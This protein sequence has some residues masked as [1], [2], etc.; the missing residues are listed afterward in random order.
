VPTI[1]EA[2]GV[3]YDPGQFYG[4]SAL[5]MLSG[6]S[7]TTYSDDEGFAFEVSGN[8]AL[9]RG[10]WKITRNTPPQ[11]DSEWRLY[12][13]SIDPGESRD[14]SAANPELF[15]DMLA[16]YRSYARNVGVFEVGPD[17]YAITALNKN[18][19][20]KA[21]HKYWPH[22]LGFMIALGAALFVIG[23]LGLAL[24]RRRAL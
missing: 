14:L 1:L 15:E 19:L 13:L 6:K 7:D 11:G 4:R 24:L 9:Y 5:P 18:L 12:D 22:A 20:S 21:L 23:K 17:D 2:A 16:E 10:K 8:A 3:A